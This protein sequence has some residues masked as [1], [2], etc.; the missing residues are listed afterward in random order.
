MDDQSDDGSREWAQACPHDWVKLIERNG[1]R[2][3]S[4]AVLDGIRAASYPVIVV[5]DADLSHPPEK[6]P[7]M[8]LALQSGQEVVVG[9]RYVSG[10]STDDQWG[11]GRWFNSFIATLL[12]KPLTTVRDPMSGFFAVH[13]N[14]INRAKS[15]NPVGY[16]IAL[17]IIIKCHATNVSEVPIHFVDRVHGESKLSLK[18]QLKYI[19]HLRRL[20]I[21]KFGTWSH[22]AQFLIVGLS[23]VAVNL[24]VLYALVWMAMPEKA[25]YAIGI[26]VSLTT[27]F[28]LNRRFTFSYARGRSIIKQ[29]LGFASACSVGMAVNYT[30]FWIF[31]DHVPDAPLW[32]ASLTGIAAGTLFNFLI[33]RHLVFRSGQ[34]VSVP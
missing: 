8:I 22:L 33:S 10:G 34:H 28:M 6:I 1:P 26:L 32:V 19:Q 30:T 2:G 4:A 21:Y 23:G 15:F 13:I 27:N 9:S 12:A 25:A 3:L 11:F 24:S 16:K 17:E 14:T 20:Y 29:F 5:M 18:E 31:T 7:D